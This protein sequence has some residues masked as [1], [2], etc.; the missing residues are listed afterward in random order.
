MI[1]KPWLNIQPIPVKFF[2][3]NTQDLPPCSKERFLNLLRNQGTCSSRF[4]LGK[5][6]VNFNFSDL[7]ICVRALLSGNLAI[8]PTETV[9][10]LAAL[11]LDENAVGKI[12]SLKGRP[13]T[14]PLIVHVLDLKMCELV[15]KINPLALKILDTFWPGPLTV[16]LPRK[17][18]IPFNTCAGLTTVAVRAPDHNLFREVLKKVN[19][20]IAAPSA[21]RSNKVSP[22]TA[23]HVL[24]NFGIDCPPI[25]NGGICKHGLEST[26]LDLDSDLPQIL[27][28]G[29]VSKEE[30][31]ECLHCKVIEA[32]AEQKNSSNRLK[33][34]GMGSK[35][36]SPRTPIILKENFNELSIESLDPNL[37][38]IICSDLEEEEN[39][40]NYHFSTLLLSKSGKL[41]EIAKNLYHTLQIADSMN[42]KR[43][44]MH[45]IQ[46]PENLATAI[47]D[48]LL[49]ASSR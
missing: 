12:F 36:Y 43:I 2:Q 9:Y 26:V 17:P 29:P 16:V 6:P 49:R 31:E 24:H 10:G 22:T 23:G 8:L 27:R 18:V 45:K 1:R 42:K 46:G 28:P 32:F 21:N 11:A 25:L 3:E 7:D 5:N 40:S 4:N 15:A 37:D 19:A 20:P 47:N 38:L 44:I 41:N 39:F 14:N 13:P 30:I 48:R 33:S 34:P 35:H